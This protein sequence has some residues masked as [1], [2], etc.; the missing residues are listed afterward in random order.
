MQGLIVSI[1]PLNG[2]ANKATVVVKIADSKVTDQSMSG[3]K[4]LELKITEIASKSSIAVNRI[5]SLPCQK[6]IKTM[7]E[8]FSAFL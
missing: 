7:H 4:G 6:H 1:Y 5:K 3:R 2:H 8:E